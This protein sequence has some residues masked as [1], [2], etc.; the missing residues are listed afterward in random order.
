MGGGGAGSV[1]DMSAD[2]AL[3]IVIFGATGFVGRL[4]AG[5]LAAHAPPD[6]RIGLGGRSEEKL[7]K[8]RGELGPAASGWALTP[9]D[10]DDPA[11]LEALASSTRVVATTVG[12]YRQYGLPLVAASAAAGT[13]YAD[14]TG[15]VLFMRES[16]ERH[17]DE[18]VSSGAKIVHACGFDSIP[19]DLGVLLLH[20]AAL[21][22]GTG[23]LEETTL[24]VTAMKGGFS[25]GTIAS[26]KHQVEETRADPALARAVADPYALSPERSGEP[27]LGP[28]RELRGVERDRTLDTWVGPFVMAS[29]NTRVVRRSNALAG[30]A[31]G[32]RFLYR[33]VMG[34]G[35]GPTAPVKAAATTAGLGA[36]QAGLTLSPTRALLD[37]ALPSPGEGPDEE[38]RRNGRFRIE[39]HTRT[40]GGA[41]YVCRV[42]AEGDP[43]Y[44]AT[45]VMM[46]E[47][48]LCLAQDRER[49]PDTSGVLTPATAV[50][51]T[52]V[53]R[54]RAAGH[55]WEVERG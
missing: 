20:E 19:S 31:Y 24:V 33:E 9:A 16:A 4:V 12:P 47:T 5:Y 26:L 2:R 10:S 18:A 13:D 8:L 29:T 21:A 32:R 15:E 54:L 44:A 38:S 23:E 46:G 49:L 42:A 30:W 1:T 25:G 6:L 14:L 50:G 43:G 7:E 17:H 37:R 36:V 27:D 41:R 48:A 11:S 3:D 40:S 45:S 51:T 35:S 28:E 53:D 34:F 55:T 52:L 39:I 22:D